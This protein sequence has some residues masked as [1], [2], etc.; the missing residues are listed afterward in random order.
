MNRLRSGSR[1]FAKNGADERLA[2]GRVFASNMRQAD[3]V[4]V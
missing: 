3:I 1:T 4:F 2:V